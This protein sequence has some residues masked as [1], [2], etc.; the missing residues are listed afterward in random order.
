MTPVLGYHWFPGEY[1]ALFVRPY[2][3]ASFN[4]ALRKPPTIEET[5][6]R[7]FFVS[8]LVGISAGLAF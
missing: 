6:L 5:S 3:G 8:P 1:D 7:R 4:Y 2:L